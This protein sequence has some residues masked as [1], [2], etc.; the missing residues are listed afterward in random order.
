MNKENINFKIGDLVFAKVRGY[1]PWPA[2][3]VGSS[4][5]QYDVCFFGTGETGK[6]S[7]H[8]LFHYAEHKEE[9]VTESKLKRKSYRAAVDESESFTKPL[10]EIKKEHVMLFNIIPEHIYDE[11]ELNDEQPQQCECDIKLEH[12]KVAEVSQSNEEFPISAVLVSR[13]LN[14]KIRS[15]AYDRLKSKI[16]TFLATMT[17]DNVPILQDLIFT[18]E[19][20][21]IKICLGLKTHVLHIDG[22]LEVFKDFK[23]F[24]FTSAILLRCPEGVDVIRKVRKF[25]GNSVEWK[26]HGLDK[27]ILT[28]KS[29]ILREEARALYNKF[30]MLFKFNEPK[31][32]WKEFLKYVKVLEKT[33]NELNIEQYMLLTED[34]CVRHCRSAQKN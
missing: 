11:M 33:T 18:S 1:P 23:R 32:F 22:A 30:K 7:V 9:F 6:I 26:L 14:Y 2:R 21:K 8:N 13:L 25:V 3:I 24:E 19:C 17:D 15:D 10:A 20:H 29:K 12:Q 4:N 5:N 34:V 31:P 28:A 16:E 27:A